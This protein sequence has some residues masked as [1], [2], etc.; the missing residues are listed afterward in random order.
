LKEDVSFDGIQLTS[1]KSILSAE[2]GES[3][4]LTAQLTYEG[5]PV[6]VSGET[7]TF[8][9]RK[10]SDDS[11][12]ESLTGATNASGI[13][14]VSYLGKATGNLN[15]KVFSANRMIVSERCS[16]EDLPFYADNMSKIKNTFIAD[17]SVTGRTIYVS[18]F[19]F[20]SDVELE[21]KLKN[22]PNNW[23]VGFGSDGSNITNK[24]VWFKIQ[25]YNQDKASI[26]YVDTGGSARDVGI[27]TDYSTSTVFTIYSDN[28][29]KI[30]WSLDTV[31]KAYRDTYTG[32]PLGLRVDVFDNQD[33][34]IEYIKVKAL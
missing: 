5:S 4:T 11:L 18:P 24:G 19:T 22:I 2:D 10:Q 3:A 34:D 8:E 32:L 31:A 7:V 13:A 12:V 21:F 26:M 20:N 16:I 15:I 25:N 17:T 30:Y 14:T 33:Y 28:I 1:N 29:H 6:A 27:T 9:V 23:V